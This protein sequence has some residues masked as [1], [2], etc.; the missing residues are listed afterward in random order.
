MPVISKTRLSCSISYQASK[1]SKN[2]NENMSFFI[3][4]HAARSLS[5]NPTVFAMVAYVKFIHEFSEFNVQFIERS[6]IKTV[7]P[8]DLIPN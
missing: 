8:Q 3:N 5:L 6:Y 2:R 7:N 4:G 1:S